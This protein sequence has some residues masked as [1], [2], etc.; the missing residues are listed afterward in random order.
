MTKPLFFYTNGSTTLK[1][2]AY[3]Y[4]INET[5]MKRDKFTAALLIVGALYFVIETLIGMI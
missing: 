3:L 2:Q 1:Y 4:V 5:K